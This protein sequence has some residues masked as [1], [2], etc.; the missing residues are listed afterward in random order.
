MV[1]NVTFI[2]VPTTPSDTCD[3][4][5]SVRDVRYG[6]QKSST[7]VKNP[8]LQQ[9]R[10]LVLGHRRY[11]VVW[12]RRIFIRAARSMLGADDQLNRDDLKHDTEQSR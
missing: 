5:H 10:Y 12:T 6:I 2:P 4:H 3:L 1:M 7:A 8:E 9:R 11:L